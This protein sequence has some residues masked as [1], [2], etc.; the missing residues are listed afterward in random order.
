MCWR[1]TPGGRPQAAG[2][3][4]RPRPRANGRLTLSMLGLGLAAPGRGAALGP[5][6]APALLPLAQ[7]Y[8]AAWNAHDLGAV[9]ALFAPD[10]VVRERWGEVPPAVWDTR[11]PRVARA[12]LDDSS[13]G[14]A[15]ATHG[16][17]WASGRPQIAA[18]AAARFAEHHRVATDQP[19]AAGDTVGWRYRELVDPFQGTPGFSPTGGSAEA[20]VRDGR[21]AVLTLVRSPE[22]GG[23]GAKRTRPWP[24]CGRRP[25]TPRRAGTGRALRPRPPGLSGG[26]RRR[27]ARRGLAPGAGRPRRAGRRHRG[28]APP[29]GPGGGA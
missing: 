4:G 8:T 20:V 28:A 21:I 22:S 25:A 14:E 6:P 3:A 19:R 1:V 5:P 11:D 15:Y 16:F 24:P 29:G 18:W 17:A 23:G 12:Y 27:T 26:R 2:A 10:A 13:S 7:A 9:L